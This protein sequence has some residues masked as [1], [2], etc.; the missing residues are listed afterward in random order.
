MPSPLCGP[1]PV[2][3]AWKTRSCHDQRTIGRISFWSLKTDS[4]PLAR[5]QNASHAASTWPVSVIGEPSHLRPSRVRESHIRCRPGLTRTRPN[6]EGQQSVAGA[7]GPRP[8]SHPI[9]ESRVGWSDGWFAIP[10]R[11][12]SVARANTALRAPP[13][14]S[15]RESRSTTQGDPFDEDHTTS[16]RSPNYLFPSLRL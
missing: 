11:S 14:P 15:P 13:G 8:T 7:S 5:C 10:V 6:A 1:T 2:V 4:V 9:H 12:C 3:V 16:M